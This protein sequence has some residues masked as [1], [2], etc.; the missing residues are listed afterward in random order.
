[1]IL[2]RITKAI[3][4]Q[5]WFAVVLEFIIVIAG[6]VIGF[7]I[8]AWNADRHDRNVERRHLANIA[9]DL[10]DDV[11]ELESYVTPTLGRIAAI[12]LV[13][14][15][16][17]ATDLD[18]PVVFSDMTIDIPEF[19]T[20]P[21][22]Q[23]G[24][25]LGN[26]NLTRTLFGNRNGFE[27]LMESGGVDLIRDEVLGQAL[28]EYYTDLGSFSAIQDLVRELRME[29]MRRGHDAGLAMFGPASLDELVLATR[30][31]PEFGAALRSN[32]DWAV[33]HMRQIGRQS[34]AARAL[35]N[36]IEAEMERSE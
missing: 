22:A 19:S 18:Q 8:T 29:S 23:Q 4:E 32:R 31:H 34:A 10:R 13:L 16:A 2:A 6:V 33:I 20:V 11:Q 28:Q 27:A 9:E 30:E 21:E 24:Q 1:M 25:L 35:L 12:H 14:E 36:E 15:S 7:Q 26:I 17:G 3:R 5:N